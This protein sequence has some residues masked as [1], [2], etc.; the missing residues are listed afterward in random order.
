[1]GA[2]A[3]EEKSRVE[4]M[5]NLLAVAAQLAR[6]ES[7][8]SAGYRLV[9]NQGPDSGQEVPHLHLHLLAGRRLSVMG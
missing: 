7:V 4:A 5:G 2:L 3:N 1:V 8:D 6:Q 9:V